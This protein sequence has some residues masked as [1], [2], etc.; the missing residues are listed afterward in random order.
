[1]NTDVSL[2]VAHSTKVLPL[3]EARLGDGYFYQSLPL[4]VIN[5]VFSIGVRY[6]GVENAVKRYC[7]NYELQMVR[8]PREIFP[9][10]SNQESISSFC[11]K[12][13][14]IGSE[15]MATSILKNTQ[16]T[17]SQSGILKSEAVYRFAVVLRTYGVEY[18]QDIER[19]LANS[20]FEKDISV[21]PGQGSGVSLKYFFMLAGSED[22]IKPDRMIDAYLFTILGRKVDS[23]E[24][25]EIL[26]EAS[27]QI[28]LYYSHITARSLDHE[29][30]KY[31]R[32]QESKLY[33]T[34]K[35]IN[36]ADARQLMSDYYYENK[37][38]LPSNIHSYREKIIELIMEGFLPEVAFSQVIA[39]R[40]KV[41]D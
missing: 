29:I 35:K 10:I 18:L 41:T 17:S 28:N 1:M 26:F 3:A 15:G 14:E 20:A 19:V 25:Q 16:R 5:A 24:A 36:D 11:N 22:L 32:T 12:M 30:W 2:I 33:D 13:Q 34:K 21:I 7:D 6:E 31:Q 23:A 9:D 37:V 40:Q 4:C 38:T 39:R 27:R 8:D